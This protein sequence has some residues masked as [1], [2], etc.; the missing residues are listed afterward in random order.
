MRRKIKKRN[1][2]QIVTNASGKAVPIFGTIALVVQ[3]GTSAQIFKY[4]VV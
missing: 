2:I 4:L 3:I 1:G